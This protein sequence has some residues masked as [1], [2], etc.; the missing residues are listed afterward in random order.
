[1]TRKL[2]ILA[3]LGVVATSGMVTSTSAYAQTNGMDR[4]DDRR[5]TR[6]DGRA[7]KAACKAGDEKSRPECRQD[8]RDTKQDGRHD[9][10]D[11][12]KKEGTDGT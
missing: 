10:N 5:D 2:L 6:D 8:K 12:D 7:E 9:V 3:A 4:R 11:K 1:M